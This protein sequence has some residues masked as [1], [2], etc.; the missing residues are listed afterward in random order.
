MGLD[1]EIGRWR[2][3]HDAGAWSDE[4][5]FKVISHARD[6]IMKPNSPKVVRELLERRWDKLGYDGLLP[7]ERNWLV[8]WWL[9][10]EVENGSFHQYFF[11]STGDSALQALSALQDMGAAETYDILK[12][13]L[14]EFDCVGGD[15]PDR[16]TR[17]KRLESI[18]NG[19]QAF[20][21][22][23][24]R[25]YQSSEDSVG[26]ALDRVSRIYAESETFRLELEEVRTN[27]LRRLPPG[28]EKGKR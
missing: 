28:S 13:A 17:Q 10:A 26:M 23:T 7:T 21:G 19:S 24:E 8:L 3:M 15:S 11:N 25:F 18:P 1:V 22:P 9:R 6:N 14:A 4:E 5:Y 20:D 12:Q 2:H 16:G 27:M